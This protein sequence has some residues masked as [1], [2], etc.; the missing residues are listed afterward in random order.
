MPESSLKAG[1]R[2]TQTAQSVALTDAQVEAHLKVM[3][4]G[5]AS[6]AIGVLQPG[7]RLDCITGG[8]F[9]LIDLLRAILEQT[10]PADVLVSAWTVGI[11]DAEVA[12]WLLHHDGLIRSLRFLV[13]DR[14]PATEPAYCGRMVDIFGPEVFTLG[15]VHARFLVVTNEKWSI[16]VRSSMNLNTNPHIEQFTLDVDKR[17]SEFY[18]NYERTLRAHLGAGCHWT[19]KQVTAAVKAKNAEDID[20]IAPL[21]AEWEQKKRAENERKAGLAAAAA[22]GRIPSRQEYL[23]AEFHRLTAALDGAIREGKSNAVS[24][25]SAQKGKIFDELSR[26]NDQKPVTL[27][28]Q[29]AAEQLSRAVEAAPRNL[30]HR[31]YLEIVARNPA[32]MEAD[33]ED[34]DEEDVRPG[35]RVVK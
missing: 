24:Q 7:Y 17:I 13:A 31:L 18:L 20:S 22:P 29:E 14:F 1:R 21:L 19:P 12:G 35:L 2:K 6:L 8:Q 33:E 15:H 34:E 10:G 11:R 28:P 26:L 25:I 9:S 4:V 5:P 32:F 30:Q 16:C 23:E 3:P 27:T